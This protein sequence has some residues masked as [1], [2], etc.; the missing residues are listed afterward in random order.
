MAAPVSRERPLRVLHGPVNIG[1]QAWSLSRAERRLGL[2]SDLVVTAS[3]AF[4]YAADRSLMV[5]GHPLLTRARRIVHGWSSA[6]RYDAMH[7]YFGR[8][9]SSADS[10]TLGSSPLTAALLGDV[11]LARRLGLRLVMT[12]QGCDARIAGESQRL[13]EWTMCQHGRCP[14]FDTCIG[15][16]DR[17]RW[18]MI[19]HLLPLMDKVFYVNPELGHWVG[20]GEFLPYASVDIA[21]VR[22]APPAANRRPLIVHAPTNPEIKGTALI[23][24]ALEHLRSRHDFDLEIVAGRSHA[25]AMAVYQRADLAVDQIL[26]GWYGGFSVEM[27]ALGKPVVCAIREADLAFVPL[28]FAADLPILKVRPS[29][30]VEDFLAILERRDTWASVG[31]RSRAFVERWHDPVRI[32]QTIIPHYVGRSTSRGEPDSRAM[33]Q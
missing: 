6:F 22:P 5:A 7:F 10:V 17:H 19:H 13:N 25:E 26:A 12:L 16:T 32:A 1:N 24:A 2:A 23:L 9:F 11:R 30:L 27:M 4:G 3:N 15:T 8:T 29:H 21:A 14:Q 18:G 33:T 28:E 20:Q 31:E